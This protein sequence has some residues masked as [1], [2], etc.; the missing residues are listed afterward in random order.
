MRER[1]RQGKRE[2]G[3]KGAEGGREEVREG[4]WGGRDGWEGRVVRTKG[5]R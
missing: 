2:V 3:R 5:G 4:G 1:G